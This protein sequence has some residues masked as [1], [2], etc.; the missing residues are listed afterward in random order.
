M[1]AAP[2]TRELYPHRELGIVLLVLGILLL[3]AAVALGGF[4]QVVSAGGPAVP[5]PSCVYPYAAGSAAL[6]L[7]G[8]ILFLVGVILI[9]TRSPAY[10]PPVAHYPPVWVPFPPPPPPAPVGLIACKGCGRVYALNQ[11]AFCP[12]CGTKLGP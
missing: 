8:F 11:Y 5:A 3:L 6:G 4:C 7:V 12:S 9:V 1:H 10:A 2:T